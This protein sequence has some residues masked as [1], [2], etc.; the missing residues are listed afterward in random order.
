[1][2]EVQL[3]FMHCLHMNIL[4]VKIVIEHFGDLNKKVNK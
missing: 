1:M 4:A 2:F 3:T